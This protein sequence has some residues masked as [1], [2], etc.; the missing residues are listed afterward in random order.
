VSLGVAFQGSGGCQTASNNARN[1]RRA[2]LAIMAD[3][4]T[5]AVADMIRAQDTE[6]KTDIG[7]QKKEQGDAEFKLGHIKEAMRAYHEATMYLSGLDRSIM[8]AVAS[9]GPKEDNEAP[10]KKRTEADE[11]L[12]KIYANMCACHIKNG[13]WKRAVESADKAL[14]RNPKNF[15]ASLRKAKAQA[16]LGWVEKAEK[17]LTGL[18]DLS[19][20]DQKQV[21]AELA[22]IRA[23]DR[24]REKQHETKFKGF[25]AREKGKGASVETKDSPESP[26]S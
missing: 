19:A 3:S 15:K 8:S 25:L 21:D 20:D 4:D 1:P 5:R 17:I 26:T 7:K 22:R 18:K 9:Q 6:S 2:T 23:A 16:E 10:E 13:N 14:D 11:L 12:E 24:V